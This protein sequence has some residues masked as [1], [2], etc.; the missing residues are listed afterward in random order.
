MRPIAH[1]QTEFPA[2]FGIPRQSGLAEGLRGRVVFEEEYRVA[3]AFRGLE[4]FSHI[5]LI[6][7]FSEAL[8]EDWSPTVKP[9]TPRPKT[10]C[11]KASTTCGAGSA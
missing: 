3:E 8:R 2:K 1:I 4:D 10:F 6:W 5:W 11:S 9:S 7:Q